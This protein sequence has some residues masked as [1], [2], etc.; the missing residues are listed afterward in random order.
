MGNTDPSQDNVLLESVARLEHEQTQY[1][2][3]TTNTQQR[4]D[5]VL[6]ETQDQVVRLGMRMR[7]IEEDSR[8]LKTRDDVG[9]IEIWVHALEDLAKKTEGLKTSPAPGQ[10]EDFE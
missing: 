4:H 9:Q 6:R 7:K 3:A 10:P 8:G 5:K 1:K 2:G